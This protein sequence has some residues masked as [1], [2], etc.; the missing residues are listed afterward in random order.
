MRSLSLL[1]VLA[2]SV[3]STFTTAEA[4]MVINEVDYDQPG[5]DTAEFV[6][7]FNSGSAS[8]SLNGYRL[9]FING[10]DPTDPYLS[11]DLSGFT[12]L[13][14]GFLVICGNGATVANC[15]LDIAPDE[16][17]IQN[18]LDGLALF[19]PSGLVDSM[20]YEGDILGVTEGLGAQ[21]DISTVTGSL[22]RFPD[23][24]DTQNNFADFHFGGIT[25]G[26]ANVPEP[27]TA[28]LLASGLIGLA[29]SGRRRRA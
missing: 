16:N 25:P 11:Q 20:S 21:A 1:V 19:D 6:E 7:L 5:T 15:D 4:V 12:V 24:L 14:G 3:F 13:S 8:V 18:S 9:D 23:G 29:I 10:A 28:L 2:L 22:S 26:T 17:L 27:T